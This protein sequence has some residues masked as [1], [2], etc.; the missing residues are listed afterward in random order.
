MADTGNQRIMTLRGVLPTFTPLPA[1]TPTTAPTATPTPDSQEL[2]TNGGFEE[3]AAW[4]FPATASRAWLHDGRGPH[5]GA[6]G[7]SRAA[8]RARCDARPRQVF[9]DLSGLSATWLG[10]L[11]PENASFSAADQTISIPA[12]TASAG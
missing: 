12:T 5:R 2:V 3:D 4:D 9:G 8:A 10:E 7:S 1:L 6:L 11:A